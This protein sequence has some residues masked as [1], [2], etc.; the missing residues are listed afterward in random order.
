MI[1]LA[2]DNNED[3]ELILGTLQKQVP[4][5][6]IRHAQDGNEAM[7]LITQWDDEPLQLVLLNVNLP[8]L[9]GL[10]VLKQLRTKPET[11]H[12]PVIMLSTSEDNNDI[13]RS[14]GLGANSFI[15]KASQSTD[16]GEAIKQIAPY[17][18][19]LNQPYIQQGP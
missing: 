6:N 12:V 16:F 4:S 10:D 1:L 5:S 3:A 9:S 14:Y 18:L 13:S 8:Q 19:A 11:S 7:K 17:W 15:N 2:E